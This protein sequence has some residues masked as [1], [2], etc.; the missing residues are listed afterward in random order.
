M[1]VDMRYRRSDF[2]AV[3]TVQGELVANVIKSHLESEGIP[4]F[5]RWEG[6]A[7]VLGLTANR[8]KQFALLS[9]MNS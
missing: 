7:R 4:A 5:L 1:S 8:N 2:V 9:I 6:V 3:C